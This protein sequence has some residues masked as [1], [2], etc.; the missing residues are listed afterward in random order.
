MNLD[1]LRKKIDR[2]DHQIV[3]LLNRR[4]AVAAD[5]GKLKRR[6]QDG[7]VYVAER[8]DQVLRKVCA[9][10]VGPLKDAALRAIYREVM[11]AAIALV[12]R[13]CLVSSPSS[14]KMSPGCISLMTISRP[15]WLSRTIDTRPD[16][17]R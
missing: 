4:L 17:S 12:D 15:S 7:R 1:S 14:P 3:E 13:G 10:N 2:L 6:R 5:I 8:E 16:R 9:Q 11:S